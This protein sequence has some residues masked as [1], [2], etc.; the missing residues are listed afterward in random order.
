MTK[1]PLQ[2]V[3]L[4]VLSLPL[5]VI[6]QNPSPVG[7]ELAILLKVKQLWNSP[8][9]LQSWTDTSSSPCGWPEVNCTAGG[10]VAELHLRD[11]NIT[12]PIP[13]IICGLKSL[14]TLDLSWNY[15]PGR[16]PQALY[17]CS[18]LLF[19]DLSQNYFV[20]P[21][22]DDIDRLS[23][24]LQYLDI[25]GNN[26]SGDIPPAIGRLSNLKTL[27]LYQNMFNGT[28]PKEIGDLSNLEILGMAYNE[29]LAPAV[30][31]EEFGRMKK[32]KFLWMT[33]CN[34]IGQIPENITNMAALEQL[35]LSQNMLTGPI[36]VGLLFSLKNLKYL[37]LYHNR[38]LGQIPA[39][40]SSLGLREI[41][42]SMNNLTGPI[43]AVFGNLQNLT[44][45]NLYSNRLSGEIPASI[46][47]LPSLVN[48]RVF[49]NNLSG[50]LP[51]DFGQYSALEAFEVSSNGFTGKLPLNLCA[52]GVLTGVVA[53]SN[54]LTGGIPESLG[55][56]RTLRT[57]QLYDNS[58]TGEVPLGI[59]T[60]FNLSSL[61]ISGNLF[62]GNLPAKIAWNLSR[63]EISNNRFSGQIPPEVSSWSRLTVFKASNNL[64]SGNIPEE[65]TNL[66]HLITLSL[67][68]NQL[69]GELP[70]TIVSWI[71]LT[72]LNVSANKIS[73]PIPAAIGSL[74]NLL[75][76]D[77]SKNQLS[78][79]I[80]PELGNLML[81]TLNLS[82]NKL[83]GRIPDEFNNQ[84]YSAS[85]LSNP[86][87]CANHPVINL[88]SCS[89]RSPNS[90][91]LSPKYLALIVLL[92]IAV[93]LATV[94]LTIRIVRDYQKKCR[95]DLATW[96]LTS[97]HRLDFTEAGILSR[98]KD[99]N[100]IGC[101]GSGKVYRIGIGGPGNYV[102]VKRIWN[103]KRVD[104][105]HEK[106]FL[107]EVEILGTI[108]HSNIVKLLCCISSED[109]KVL[110]YEYKENES[111]DRWLH[112]SK[113]KSLAVSAA[114]SVATR[115][116][117][118]WPTRLQIAVGAAQGLC[119][120]H[121]DCSPPIIHRDV[122]SSNILLDSEFNASIADFGLAKMMA[123]QGEAHTMSAI[124][125]SFG[126]FAPEYAYT[127]KVNE[128][129]DVY[130]FGVVLLELV[131]GKEPNS[132]DENSSLAEW[133]WRHFT[134]GKLI[135]EALDEEIKTQ[136]YLD[137]MT[138]VFKLGLIC[139]SNS[140][141][142]RPSMKEVLQILRKCSPS[143][144]LG[145]KKIGRD[146]DAIP[147]LRSA[148]YLSSYRK[149][150]E[151]SEE[152]DSLVYIV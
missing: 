29:N 144:A 49:T 74:P 15:I 114:R 145:G 138:T 66:S 109:S 95:S 57:V 16:F 60:L 20:G 47:K 107:A 64:L 72:I 55:S 105:K 67:D 1:L 39:S 118:D 99:E 38:L 113:R 108:R 127:T 42:L 123:D 111:L 140:P 71:S 44:L 22:P 46:G 110:V 80:P 132:G 125:G 106:E 32:L 75:V 87:L 130:S 103:G 4:Y 104:A 85:F 63:I 19:L 8:D 26:F 53:F 124:A 116:F 78:G 5:I 128:K 34:L 133:A 122:K 141:A 56:C 89:I 3:L 13:P 136:S 143:E 76:L 70:S 43:P 142:S 7:D 27:N 68:G 91:K 59:W 112:R 54:N 51:P 148:T 21:V 137:D 2:M 25:G 121:H 45:I 150:H 90:E 82:S 52:K 36:P 97:F 96:K 134:E 35:D 94:S 6:S 37:Y 61:M 23:S 77:M 102:A 92:A 73:G 129:I 17:N 149:S 152:D 30:I 28:F 79:V 98:L 126:Y 48:F 65:L 101:G 86:N 50:T 131:T 84:A 115:D 11:K 14:T 58:F 88:R 9:L 151:L 33:R 24:L 31:P 12:E 93:L 83:S 119:Y 139:T 18:S 81:N 62:S 147:L 117:L 10:A 41:D 40:V 69:S 120:M 146:F 100:L 135:T